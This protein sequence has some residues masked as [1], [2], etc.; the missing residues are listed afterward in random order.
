MLRKKVNAFLRWI[1]KYTKTDMVYLA[2]GGSWFALEKIVTIAT[3]FGLSIAFANLISQETFGVYKYILSVASLVSTF[4][5]SGVG[6][7]LTRSV[8][9]GYDG[10]YRIAFWTKVRWTLPVSILSLVGAAYYAIAGNDTLAAGLGVI[11]FATPF[12]QGANLHSAFL[13]GKKLFKQA[14]IY[15]SWINIVVSLSLAAALWFTHS[16]VILVCVYFLVQLLAKA[17]AY[18]A[19]LQYITPSPKTDPDSTSYGKKL[20]AI[21]FLDQVVSYIDQV[22][23]FQLV[24]AV[25]VA[26]FS[27][28]I[29]PP[30]QLQVSFK[31]ISLLAYPK[32]A[33]KS[34]EDIQS[35]IFSKIWRY[36][37]ITIII[38][39]LY[40]LLAP[41]MYQWLFPSYTSAIIYSQILI[42]SVVFPNEILRR[43]LFSQQATKELVT[44]GVILNTIKLGMLVGG[45]LLFGL[46]GAVIGRV[47]SRILS[48]IALAITVKRL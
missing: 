8:A 36:M 34:K 37:F 39:V 28:A 24:G 32:F 41:Y 11:A 3:S 30:N 35:T 5:L 48:F 4:T 6:P 1:E 38:A 15:Q 23:L 7:A 31:S 44:L 13:H 9:C 19:S 17:I 20:T 45:I 14:A 22:L 26:L 18:V 25:E 10:S 40:I 42:I 43:V 16:V 2:K 29:N 47:T 46:W 33:N 21:E 12:T 27:F